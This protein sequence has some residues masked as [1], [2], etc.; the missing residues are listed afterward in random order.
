[1]NEARDPLDDLLDRALSAHGKGEPRP[2]LE[3]RVLASLA[4]RA[5]VPFWHQLF[6]SRLARGFSVA[7]TVILIATLLS[8][9]R[10]AGVT[11]GTPESPT[12][13]P[14]AALE[15]PP[16]PK[17]APAAPVSGTDSAAVSSRRRPATRTVRRHS[18]FPR[19]SPLSKQEVLLLRYVTDTPRDEMNSHAG[20]LDEPAELPPLPS[21]ATA[22]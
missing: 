13:I 2:G 9:D 15:A 18:S 16:A 1:M 3:K 14:V 12:P 10:N 20:F 7:M 11:R 6:T 4:P 17:A 22:P 8:L 5:A 21:S 19:P